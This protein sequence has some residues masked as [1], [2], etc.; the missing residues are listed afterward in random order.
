M[1][2]YN[3]SLILNTILSILIMLIGL[4]K[5]PLLKWKKNHS[6]QLFLN[7]YRIAING[8]LMTIVSYFVFVRFYEFFPWTLPAMPAIA[9]IMQKILFTDN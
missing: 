5:L 4:T 7:K 9:I 2:E 8:V 6:I 1:N 3:S